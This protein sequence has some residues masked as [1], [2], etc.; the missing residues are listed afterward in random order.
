MRTCE[1]GHLNW[2]WFGGFLHGFWPCLGG[3]YG[4]VVGGVSSPD[5]APPRFGSWRRCCRRGGSGV[6]RSRVELFEQ[7][8]K[9]AGSRVPRSGSWPAGWCRA[10]R[11]FRIAG[12]IDVGPW[13]RRDLIL[14]RDRRRWGVSDVLALPRVA[15]SDRPGVAASPGADEREA[16]AQEVRI[17][18]PGFEP[19]F[20]RGGHH[21][22]GD[23]RPCHGCNAE[24]IE[25][26]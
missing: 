26:R 4:R 22:R 12:D 24:P 6:A 15:L 1:C 9:T 8:R 25:L 19:G 3:A 17:V 7:I 23:Q 18:E 20:L 11:L 14:L 2:L 13:P 16:A 5:L 21:S 10:R